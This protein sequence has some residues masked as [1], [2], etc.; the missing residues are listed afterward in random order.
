MPPMSSCQLEL[1][2]YR[3][4]VG[5]Y[6]VEIMCAPSLPYLE[7]TTCSLA[8]QSY[9]HFTI[10]MLHDCHGWL[11]L[12]G[13]TDCSVH[14]L[15]PPGGICQ[16]HFLCI[17]PTKHCSLCRMWGGHFL[18]TLLLVAASRQGETP[19]SFSFPTLSAPVFPASSSH[20]VIFLGVFASSFCCQL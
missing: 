6:L 1:S 10:F 12:L 17:L 15:L 5:N 9:N 16:L 7:N 18:T 2:L 14:T 13:H 3:S 19:S 4:C 8:L 20:S 11:L